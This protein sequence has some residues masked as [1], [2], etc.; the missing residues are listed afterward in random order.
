MV[1]ANKWANILT[2]NRCKYARIFIPV[3]WTGDGNEECKVDITDPIVRQ[4]A[5]FKSVRVT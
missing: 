1:K 4:P 2:A 3:L 5:L